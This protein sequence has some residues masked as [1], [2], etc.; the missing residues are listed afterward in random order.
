MKKM[1]LFSDR[2]TLDSHQWRHKKQTAEQGT[3]GRVNRALP[4]NTE[5]KKKLGS[6]YPSN[7]VLEI[8][9]Y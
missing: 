2:L 7:P 8:R 1:S 4:S 3:A 5:S 9:F 6:A